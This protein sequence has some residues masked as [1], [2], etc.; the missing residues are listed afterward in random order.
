LAEVRDFVAKHATDFGFKK[1]D[2]AD[3]RLAV[4]EAYTNIIKHAYKK[5]ERKSVDIE[6]GYNN[7]SEFWISL[8]DT[9]DAFDPSDYSK[10]D[11]RKKIKEKKRGGVGVYLIKK[12]MD[13]VEYRTEGSVNEIRMTKRK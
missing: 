9:G 13:S 4:D 3:I 8:L 12:L 5:D 10:P 2:V 7:S 6:L 1:Q 11:V